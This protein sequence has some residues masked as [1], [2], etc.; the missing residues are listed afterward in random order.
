MTSSSIMRFVNLS[1]ITAA[2]LVWRCSA[3]MPYMQIGPPKFKQWF[4]QWGRSHLPTGANWDVCVPDLEQYWSGN[5]TNP[6]QCTVVLNCILK[7]TEEGSK[8]M[9]A[10][11]MVLLSFIPSIL[12]LICPSIAES[13][14]LSLDQPFLSLLLALGA[15]AV[16]TLR[17][18][19]YE[20]PLDIINTTKRPREDGIFIRLAV[21]LHPY[22]RF[23]LTVEHLLVLLAIANVIQVSLDLG[24]RSVSSFDCDG[25]YY[26]LSW[27]LVPA[28]LH[29]LAVISFWVTPRGISRIAKGRRNSSGLMSPPERAK[30]DTY[31]LQK[32][33]INQVSIQYDTAP[34]DDRLV[35]YTERPSL[36]T[37]ALQ[38]IATGCAVGHV[39]YGTMVFSTLMFL[40]VSDAVPVIMRY[41]L[42]AVVCRTIS[43]YELAVMSQKYRVEYVDTVEEKSRVYLWRRRT[44][45]TKLP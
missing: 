7:G 23:V 38:Y 6:Y 13:A 32:R 15:S 45:L 31:A 21:A 29:L 26:P 5:R 16:Y 3:E 18:W 34:R 25:S 33:H 2:L 43:R 27:V 4:S 35:L 36:W 37:L 19:D 30:T 41:A 17:I 10:A 8:Q 9:L 42:S 14:M 44:R 20:D 39:L 40:M 1:I 11:S 28:F 22:R 24:W 12:A